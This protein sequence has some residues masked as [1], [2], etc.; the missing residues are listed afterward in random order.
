MR[1]S[2]ASGNRSLPPASSFLPPDHHRLQ[3]QCGSPLPA[4]GS[5][6]CTSAAPQSPSTIPTSRSPSINPQHDGG[7]EKSNKKLSFIFFS[8]EEEKK[9]ER[10]LLF[11]FQFRRIVL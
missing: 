2:T 11:F 8:E 6:G 7:F 4:S 9:R 10:G 1:K 3:T 5:P